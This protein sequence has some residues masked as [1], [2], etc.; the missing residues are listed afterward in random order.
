MNHTRDNLKQHNARALERLRRQ[1]SGTGAEQAPP[2][3]ELPA[4]WMADMVARARD[5]A[6][7]IGVTA[8]IQ[9]MTCDGDV[10][11]TIVRRLGPRIDQVRREATLNNE[12]VEAEA[13]QFVR[14][15]QTSLGIPSQEDRDEFAKWRQGVASA[16]QPPF[17]AKPDAKPT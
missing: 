14:L 16:Q 3:V 2:R 9:T 15:V 12:P 11:A 7:R 5:L 8:D 1:A 4:G 10:A 6:D 17:A 13:R